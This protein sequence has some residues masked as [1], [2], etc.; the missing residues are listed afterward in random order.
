MPLP[1]PSEMIE[2]H[3]A[4]LLASA[5]DRW[6]GGLI[7]LFQPAEEG[8]LPGEEGGAPLMVNTVWMLD[9]VSA[10]DQWKLG[11]DAGVRAARRARASRVPA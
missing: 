10:Y 5:K 9:A 11:Q 3:S 4:A 7:V 1:C 8:S 6:S 2:R